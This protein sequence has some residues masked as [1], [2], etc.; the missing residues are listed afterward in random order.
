MYQ[1]VHK[2]KNSKQFYKDWCLAG[3]QEC[4]KIWKNLCCKANYHFDGLIQDS[5]T[6][7]TISNYYNLTKQVKHVIQHMA[8]YWK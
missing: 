8:I 5:L 1:L 4:T 6:P 7:N 3:T 2:L